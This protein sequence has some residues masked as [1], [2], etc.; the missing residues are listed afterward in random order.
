MAK[1]ADATKA[2]ATQHSPAQRPQ[3]ARQ[4]HPRLG[5]ARRLTGTVGGGK[6]A[7]SHGPSS[8]PRPS[9]SSRWTTT[10]S[11]ASLPI[12]LR[13]AAAPGSL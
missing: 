2:G 10:V 12:A 5:Q 3:S 1:S 7:G 13:S 11:P 9:R 6:A 4:V 8:P